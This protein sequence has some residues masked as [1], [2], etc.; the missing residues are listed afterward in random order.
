MGI[1]V[2]DAP[3]ALT[4]APL[5]PSQCETEWP[6]STKTVA[7]SVPCVLKSARKVPS[8]WLR[9]SIQLHHCPVAKCSPLTTVGR[10]RYSRYLRPRSRRCTAGRFQPWVQHYCGLPGRLD[11]VWQGWDWTYGNSGQHQHVRVRP[12]CGADPTNSCGAAMVAAV[13]NA[14]EGNSKTA[15]RESRKPSSHLKGGEQH[16]TWRQNWP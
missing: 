1:D 13:G 2:A 15:L 16:A 5:V 11:H 6:S 7:H 14:R 4:S 9:L 3:P 12:V 10:L 8:C